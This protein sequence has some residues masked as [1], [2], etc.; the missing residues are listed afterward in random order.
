[1]LITVTQSMTIINASV[2]RGILGYIVISTSMTVCPNLVLMG[3]AKTPLV[4]TV[5][6]ATRGTL[7]VTVRR[8]S[9]NKKV[10]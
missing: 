2:S 6:N 10:P 1:M 3:N 9:K 4:D 8:K 7:E 5:V